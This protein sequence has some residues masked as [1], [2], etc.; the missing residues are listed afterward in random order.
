MRMAV[1]AG[2]DL[3][4]LVTIIVTPAGQLDFDFDELL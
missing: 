3:A 1:L 4:E 2:D